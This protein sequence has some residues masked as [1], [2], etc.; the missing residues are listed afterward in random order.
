MIIMVTNPLSDESESGDIPI[1]ESDIR[2]FSLR[3]KGLSASPRERTEVRA[4]V[5]IFIMWTLGQAL[6]G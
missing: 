5:A 2:T 1:K 3:E 4:Y 6:T